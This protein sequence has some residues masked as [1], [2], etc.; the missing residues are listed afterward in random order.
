MTTTDPAV[1]IVVPVRNE[2][3]NIAPLVEEIA[4]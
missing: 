4:A 3:G 1:S 2:A